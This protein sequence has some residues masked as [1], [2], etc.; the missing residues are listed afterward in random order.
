M[1]CRPGFIG[2]CMLLNMATE[3]YALY[4][5]DELRCEEPDASGESE[6]ED[7]EVRHRR[8]YSVTGNWTS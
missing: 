3:D 8:T 5:D 7:V 1:T 6:E 2:F 4:E